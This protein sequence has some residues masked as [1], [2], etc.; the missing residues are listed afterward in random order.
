MGHL[1]LEICLLYSQQS[2]VGLLP[3]ILIIEASKIQTAILV[4]L[5]P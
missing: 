2:K 5:R 3:E 4:F 1:V